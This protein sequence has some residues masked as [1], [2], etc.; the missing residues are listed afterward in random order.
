MK[1]IISREIYE[2]MEN[3]FSK[4]FQLKFY[5]LSFLFIF[6]IK[7]KINYQNNVRELFKL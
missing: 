4:V 5:F 7:K 3:I 6:K 2:K 1:K